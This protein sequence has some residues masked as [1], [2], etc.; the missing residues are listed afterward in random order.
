MMGRAL[1]LAHSVKKIIPCD[2]QNVCGLIWTFD[3]TI[4]RI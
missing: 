2:V 3:M 1:I 4:P